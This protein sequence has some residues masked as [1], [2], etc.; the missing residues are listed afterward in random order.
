MSTVPVEEPVEAKLQS[1][2]PVRLGIRKGSRIAPLV[3]LALMVLAF[4]LLN[5]ESGLITIVNEL[6]LPLDTTQALTFQTVYET[7]LIEENAALA[8][9]RIESLG[10]G[11]FFSKLALP[12][13]Q[14]YMSQLLSDFFSIASN[15]LFTLGQ[16][17]LYAIVPGIAGLIYRRNFW[18]WFFVSFA[19]LFAVNMS[20]LVTLASSEEMPFSGAIFLFIISQIAFLL[21]ANRLRRYSNTTSKIP[22]RIYNTGL[23]I[24]LGLIGLAC[25]MGWGP[26]RD[27]TVTTSW[28]WSFLG[29]GLTGLLWQWE[30][31][32]I[33][34]PAIY[35][36]LR[37]SEH[38]AGNS[39]KNIVV[40][41]DGTSN[42]PEQ[43]E[44]G[45]LAQTNVFKLFNMLKSDRRF[46]FAPTDQFDAS[47]CKI[48]KQK[49]V[50]FYYAGVGN[51]FDNDPITQTLGMAAGL[52]ATGVVERA[53]LDILRVYRPGDHVFLFGFS[54]GAAI[55]RLLARTIDAR[56]A[57]DTVWTLRLFGRHWTIWQSGK[58]RPIPIKVVGC[59][60]T[61]GAFGIAKTIAG[62]NFQKINM[63][64]DLS[65]PENVERAYHMV[66]MDEMRDSFEPTLMDPDPISPERIVEVWFAGDHANIGGGWATDK[67]SD[68][69][70]D[71][72]LQHIS[73]GYAANAD[74][75][76][77]N[78]DWGLCLSA[79][80][81]KTIQLPAEEADKT[82]NAGTD[83]VTIHPDPLGQLRSWSSAL[84]T[85]QPR[86]M[87]LHAV[88]SETVFERMTSAMP[89]YAPQSLFN[90]NE[91]LDNKRDTIDAAVARLVETQSLSAEEQSSILEYKGKLRLARWPIYRD[92]IE[93]ERSPLT[94]AER[95]SHD[96][97]IDA[98]GSIS[99]S[100]PKLDLSPEQLAARRDNQT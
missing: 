64:K 32:L 92:T 69:T 62:I 14:A 3:L 19:L 95:L 6:G 87:P 78:E 11:G 37:K 49:Q 85:Y 1:P 88:I 77:G 50:A 100:R 60:D 12:L 59:W 27:E 46:G 79:A 63:F 31:I 18:S 53:Y 17:A 35:I 2:K 33:A 65:I 39:P 8:R 20:G 66:A 94:P 23:A 82:V 55:S 97:F 56:G 38:W 80:N 15:T 90:L 41:L 58:R 7:M 70:L 67:L 45:L 10:L 47:L 13:G 9:Q 48:Y 75:T 86:Q 73:S 40:C 5:S 30:F 42:T 81:G 99:A 25:F 24:V 98:D 21:L 71:F 22:T 4:V 91:D 68:I 61:V 54:R 29:D 36:L 83:M 51:R 93:K 89:V 52:G 96:T 84:Y 74:T 57:P 28:I 72:L 26:G 16:L 44:R 34:L 76:P 43:E